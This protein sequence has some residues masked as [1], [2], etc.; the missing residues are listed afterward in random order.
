[1]SDNARVQTQ[2]RAGGGGVHEGEH[3][4]DVS[5]SVAVRLGLSVEEETGD[6]VQR[7]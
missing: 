7:V 2:A 6:I 1:M 3:G 4:A 5:N